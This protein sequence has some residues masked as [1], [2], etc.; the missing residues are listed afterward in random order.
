MLNIKDIQSIEKIFDIK[1]HQHF[2]KEVE[3]FFLQL[4][5]EGRDH[6]TALKEGFQDQVQML[7]ELIQDRPT[8]N[9]VKDMI[10]GAISTHRL[11]DH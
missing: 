8:R 2:K 9:E 4:S 1:I 7:A 11:F 10:D 3:P 5:K 6:M